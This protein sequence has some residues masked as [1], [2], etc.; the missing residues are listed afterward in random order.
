M[1]QINEAGSSGLQAG[2]EVTMIENN[3]AQTP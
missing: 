3:R 1:K 2:E